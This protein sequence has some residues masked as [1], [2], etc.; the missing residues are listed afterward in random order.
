MDQ[1]IVR[2]DGVDVAMT[3]SGTAA[4]EQ[5]LRLSADE[6]PSVVQ[7]LWIGERSHAIVDAFPSFPTFP[8]F[9]VAEAATA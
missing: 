1:F 9:P 2:V 8:T 7:V 6:P 3:S 5:A 4:I